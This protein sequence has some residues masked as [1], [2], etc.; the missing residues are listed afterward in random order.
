MIRC[1]CFNRGLSEVCFVPGVGRLPNV[2]RF[3][4]FELDVRAGELRSHYGTMVRLPEQSLRILLL[5]LEHP[6]EVVPREE[7]RK[8]LWPNDTVVEFDHSIHTAIKK[9]R[10]AFGDSGDDPKYI[11]TV[12][13]RGY[14]LMVPVERVDATPVSSPVAAVAPASA[15]IPKLPIAI[16]S[17]TPSS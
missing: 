1:I 15:T 7:I 3:Q 13:R 11:E 8:K 9:L 12:A 14:R 10:N 5:L 4:S 2:A 16:V 17:T 6:D